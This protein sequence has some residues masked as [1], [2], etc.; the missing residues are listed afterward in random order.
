MHD[1]TRDGA[2]TGG[3]GRAGLLEQEQWG[4]ALV[5]RDFQRSVDAMQARGAKAGASA[6]G[7][8]P[9]SPGHVS[10][11]NGHAGAAAEA[12][13]QNGNA[14]EPPF[15]CGLSPTVT[16]RTSMVDTPALLAYT[17]RTVCSVFPALTLLF[18][19]AC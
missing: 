10:S 3:V 9:G 7:G 11:S 14:G 19:H 13:H 2:D 12:A 5:A 15:W 16:M 4:A 8:P 6:N 17:V 18:T 1:V